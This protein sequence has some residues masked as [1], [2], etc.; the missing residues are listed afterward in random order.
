MWEAGGEGPFA[1]MNADDFYGA[2]AYRML[3]EHLT[4]TGEHALIGYPLAKTLSPHGGVSR[5]I[6]EVDARGYLSRLTEVTDITRPTIGGELVSMNLWGFM[7][8]MLPALQRQF[9]RFLEIR[10]A[11]PTPE[12]LLS[13]AVGAQVA[14]G[15]A[16]VRVLPARERWFGMTFS[17]DDK[18]VRAGLARLVDAGGYPASLR[19]G[20]ERLPC[21]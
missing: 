5:A 9:A 15:E 6:A 14:A 20:F 8:A 13:E 21:D 12:F 19:T 18:D 2:D 4:T 16:R 10:G 17:S 1:V 3:F 7:P 11:D